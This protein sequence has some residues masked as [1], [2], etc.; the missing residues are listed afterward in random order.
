[1]SHSD[2]RYRGGGSGGSALMLLMLCALFL[3]VMLMAPSGE[4]ASQPAQ[5]GGGGGGWMLSFDLGG[6]AATEREAMRQATEQQRI[7]AEEATKRQ[8]IAAEQQARELDSL[9]HERTLGTVRSLGWMVAIA[10]VVAVVVAG[11]VFLAYHLGRWWIRYMAYKSTLDHDLAVRRL[12]AEERR[13][14][15]PPPQLVAYA[16]ENIPP[17]WRDFAWMEGRWWAVNRLTRER[18]ALPD[19]GGG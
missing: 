1:M 14:A 7:A 8:R 11:G 9:D 3:V 2:E 4:I 15:G 13:G 19:K 18:H 10:V 17:D 16:Q 5:E 6:K 12:A